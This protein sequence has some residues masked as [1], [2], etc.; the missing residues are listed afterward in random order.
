[1]PT[2]IF[3]NI[4]AHGHTNPTLPVVQELVRRGARVIYYSTETF[5]ARIESTGALFRSYGVDRDPDPR[6][7]DGVFQAM[8]GLLEAGETII[9]A[10]LDSVRDEKPDLILYDSMCV[11]GK[12]I[13]QLLG[14][15]AIC[16]CSLFYMGT[17][18][19]RSVP[20]NIISPGAMLR[21]VPGLL[22]GLM[23]YRRAANRIHRTYGVPSP[24]PL[25]FFGNPGDMTLVYTSRY[26]QLGAERLGGDFKFVGPSIAPRREDSGFPLAWLDGAAV[27][28]ISLGTIF[29]RHPDFYRA[30]LKAFGDTSYRVVMSVGDRIN[31]EVLGAIPDNFL[32][33]PSAP[34]LAVLEKAGL[35]IT[36]GGMNSASESAWFGVPMLVVPQGGGD[37]PFV[38]GRVEQLGA[39]L[40]LDPRRVTAPML[41]QA[42]EKV[43]GEPAFRRLSQKIGESFRAAGGYRRAA[44]EIFAFQDSLPAVTEHKT[45]PNQ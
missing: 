16:S 26:F 17:K 23:R 14:R 19:R 39:G 37:Q 44:D 29:N 7:F 24:A 18:N 35:F 38:A 43:I 40:A 1:M 10:I 28:Y 30:C 3:F 12:Q 32:V 2:F 21:G 31:T 41:R 6:Q 25:D 27:I 8:C 22:A 20:R 5:R 42:A 13:A 36:H 9:P 33:Y 11:W 34:Q 15:P 45:G 4:P